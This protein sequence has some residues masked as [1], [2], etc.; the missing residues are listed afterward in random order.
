M[1]IP[2]GAS[3]SGLSALDKHLSVIDYKK[4]QC[5]KEVSAPDKTIEKFQNKQV[6]VQAVEQIEVKNVLLSSRVVLEK[7]DYKTLVM[8][9][10]K[11]VVQ[12]RKERK[13]EK[14]CYR[15]LKKRLLD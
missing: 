13:L 14:I 12:V 6:D 2:N 8:A 1:A 5:V 9:S 10:Q 7:D 15:L 11:Y 4:V 3:G